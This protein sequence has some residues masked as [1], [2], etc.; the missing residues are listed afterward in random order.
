MAK[1]AKE[2]LERETQL[3][4]RRAFWKA[5]WQLTCEYVHQRRADF[6]TLRA[7][8]A[9]ISS[10]LWTDSPSHLAETSASAFLGY[11]WA[12]GVKSFKLVGNK[13]VFEKDKEMEDF[14]AET[15][16]ALQDE[17]DDNDASLSTTLD[18]TMLDLI[19]IGTDA[20]VTN[21][22][23]ADKP[24]LGCL[25]FDGWSVQS[26]S[27]AENASGR[28]DTFYRRREYTVKQEVEKFGL[29]NVSSKVREKFEKGQ[30][31][32]TVEVLHV[33]EPRLEKD[34]KK[35]SMAAKDMPWASVHIEIDTK[36]FI[37]ISGFQEL[38]VAC[39]RLAK[40]TNEEYGRGRGMNALPS[41]MML[42]QVM[43]DWLLAMEK[44]LDP[45]MYQLNDSVS[46]NGKID[47]SV[48]AI[49]ILRVDKAQGN[50]AP[51][52]KIFDIQEIKAAPEVITMLT[53]NISNHFMIDRLINLNNEVEMT[54]GEALL[55]NAIRQS[56]LR[57]I[58]SRILLEK[59]NPIINTSF[60]ICLRRNKFGYM[61]GDPQ[62]LALEKMGRKV[63][64]LP[65][66]FIDA[67]QSGEDLYSIEYLTPAARDMMA[68]EA[69]GMVETLGL[70]AQ[71]AAFDD[72]IKHR[73]DPQW[74]LSRFAEINGADRRMFNN[75]EKVEQLVEQERQ[76]QQ[77]A[78]AAQL[79]QMGAG[80]AK[81][82]SQAQKNARGE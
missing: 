2:Y 15:T 14:W 76:M 45:P 78:Q 59:F 23:N 69:Q 77:Q 28:A 27:L 79:M 40:R 4:T 38:P 80:A 30:L 58:V 10:Q 32:E 26:F 52:G 57:S 48:G 41:I 18:E 12:A 49:N 31:S 81:D 71:M 11:I 42:N 63:K 20:V 44:N 51:T 5:Q 35:R 22:R 34:R 46:G 62:A 73:I 6:T 65:Q 7:P 61:P 1:T 53:E 70:A 50:V 36:K 64:Y 82:V 43:E 68:E 3:E 17:M 67:M 55:R 74:S 19:T 24:L 47:T 9:F 60:S 16:S 37:K 66:K 72:T 33:I 13:N 8:G 75:Q 29:E 21:E 25:A 39:A 56:T 54:K